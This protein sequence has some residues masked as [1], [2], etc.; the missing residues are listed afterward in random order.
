MSFSGSHFYEGSNYDEHNF[1]DFD[2]LE[3][4]AEILED[5]QEQRLSNIARLFKNLLK[6]SNEFLIRTSKSNEIRN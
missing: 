6:K 2:D 4:N 3:Y 5:D 1:D